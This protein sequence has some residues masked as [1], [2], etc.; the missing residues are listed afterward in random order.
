LDAHEKRKGGGHSYD[1]TLGDDWV[2]DGTVA[3]LPKGIEKKKEGGTTDKG[4]RMI[5]KREWG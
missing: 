1:K 3:R 2:L 5:V 4:S